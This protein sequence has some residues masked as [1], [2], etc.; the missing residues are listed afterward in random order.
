MH[1]NTIKEIKQMD[2]MTLQ[3]QIRKMYK[4]MNLSD[5]RFEKMKL[6]YIK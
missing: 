2:H 3:I 5:N 1:I 4:Q 6:E